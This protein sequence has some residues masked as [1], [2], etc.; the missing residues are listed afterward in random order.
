MGGLRR[1]TGLALDGAA[2][3]IAEQ[4]TGRVLRLEPSGALTVL[5]AG[6]TRP[7]W[8]AAAPDGTLYVTADRL[9]RPA[10][11]D[12]EDDGED[13]EDDSPRIIVRRD[14]GTGALSVVASGLRQ[15]QGVAV[16]GHT[17]YAAVKRVVGLA[18]VD[19]AVARFPL[20]PGGAL[21]APSYLLSAGVLR[22]NHVQLSWR[23]FALL[24]SA[25]YTTTPSGDWPATARW[26]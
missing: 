6:L 24:R 22:Q 21:G 23:R 15:L 25:Q 19:G 13:A 1:P 16:N 5:A 9:R 3:L 26:I 4:T 20:L 10:D 2:L 14:P 7:R 18:P 8:L 12:E 11:R 17:L